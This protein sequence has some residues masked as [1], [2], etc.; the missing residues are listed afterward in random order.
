MGFTTG[1]HVAY[2]MGIQIVPV[3]RHQ[4]VA[5]DIGIHERLRSRRHNPAL[6]RRI[7][8]DDRACAHDFGG[9]IRR[10]TQRCFRFQ[11]NPQDT[12]SG[13]HLETAHHGKQAAK[14]GTLVEVGI[15]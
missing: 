8:K 1:A 2:L 11:A 13:V 3:S 7:I 6:G 12:P 5:P 4:R 14:P 15:E 10:D 9:S